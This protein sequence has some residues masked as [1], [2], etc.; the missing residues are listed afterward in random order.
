MTSFALILAFLTSFGGGLPHVSDLAQGSDLVLAQSTVSPDPT[1]EDDD[2]DTPPDPE[3]PPRGFAREAGEGAG[4]TAGGGGSVLRAGQAV[5]APS[6]NPEILLAGSKAQLDA[7]SA[8]AADMGGVVLRRKA[9]GNLGIGTLA[10][11]SG[12]QFSLASLQGKLRKA[13]IAVKSGWNTLYTQSSEPRLYAGDLIGSDNRAGCKLPKAQKIGLIDGPLD[14]SALR[15][16]NI[17]TH[18]VLPAGEPAGSTNHATAVASLIVAPPGGPGSAGFAI[19]AQLYAVTAFGASGS[20]DLAQVDTITEGLDWLLGKQV[21]VIGLP[22]TGP[23]N[24]I[25]AT[26]LGLAD[27][28]GAVMIAPVGNNGQGVVGFPAADAHVIAVTA[29][30]AKRRLYSRANQGSQT[31]FSAPGVDLY[32]PAPG[33]FGYQSGTSFAAGIVTALA[34]QQSARGARGRAAVVQQLRSQVEDLGA[35]GRDTAFGYGLVRTDGC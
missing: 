12:G 16:A 14:A 4:R 10:L 7:A 11:D 33:G 22:F 3:K 34:G 30:D 6:G 15:G 32:L 21:P 23:Q 18:S 9:H 25:L 27:A 13:E 29:L 26:V 5:L 24:D 35:P 19:G 8:L 31:D 20:R 17:V 1:G 2:P 28:Q